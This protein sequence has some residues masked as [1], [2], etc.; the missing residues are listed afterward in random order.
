M[1]NKVALA[2]TKDPDG[3]YLLVKVPFNLEDA[4]VETVVKD[5]RED[6]ID[7]FKMTAAELFMGDNVQ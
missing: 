6:V 2:V 5:V 4:N 7:R 3:K 1:S